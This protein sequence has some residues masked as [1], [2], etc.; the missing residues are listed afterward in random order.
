M[1]K[2]LAKHIKMVHKKEELAHDCRVCNKVISSMKDIVSGNPLMPIPILIL[3]AQRFICASHL[4]RHMRRHTG[5]KPFER[6]QCFKVICTMFKKT[7]HQY[8]NNFNSN[9]WHLV[10]P[11]AFRPTDNLKRHVD[12][13][14]LEEK[15]ECTRVN[16]L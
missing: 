11:Q 2:R 6:D 10:L 3:F 12:T 13:V 9:V 4:A 8:Y 7:H 14:H 15:S 16:K 5:E 1:V